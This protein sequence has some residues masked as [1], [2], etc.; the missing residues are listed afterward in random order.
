MDGRYVLPSLE[1]GQAALAGVEMPADLRAWILDPPGRNAYPIVTYTWLLCFKDYSDAPDQAAA[2]K[3]VL[4]FGLTDGQQYSIELGYIPL[5][6]EVAS[7]VLQAVD[8]ILPG[9]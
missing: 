3:N 5:P 1:T 8:V 9:K 4:R 7:R 2:L 6:R